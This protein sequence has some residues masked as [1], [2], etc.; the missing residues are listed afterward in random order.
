MVRRGY[1]SARPHILFNRDDAIVGEASILSIRLKLHK[2]WVE[3]RGENPR[4]LTGGKLV[5][6]DGT[7]CKQVGH[8]RLAVSPPQALRN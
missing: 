3:G 2:S 6:V 1:S 7:V 4:R 5:A 8:R